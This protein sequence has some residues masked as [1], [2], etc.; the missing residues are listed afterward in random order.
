[1]YCVVFTAIALTNILPLCRKEI[2]RLVENAYRRLFTSHLHGAE[3]AL[4]AA[5]GEV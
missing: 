5:V 1:M 4:Y 2:R 3:D